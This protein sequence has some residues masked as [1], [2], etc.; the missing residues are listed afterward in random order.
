MSTRR[1][2]AALVAFAASLV[3]P[4]LAWATDSPPGKAVRE[5]I[6][7][8]GARY[9][10]PDKAWI[11]Q[12]VSLED[13]CRARF[14]MEGDV[15]LVVSPLATG[16]A[17][18]ASGTAAS[19]PATGSGA[20]VPTSAPGKNHGTAKGRASLAEVHSAAPAVKAALAEA[21]VRESAGGGFAPTWLIAVVLGAL[22]T[23]A[24]VRIVRRN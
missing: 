24:A 21:Q 16:V 1:V 10:T 3:L 12:Y 13:A 6:E 15:T 18:K 8:N 22:L 19:S 4:G 7:R 23:A 20:V 2:L 17:V 14:G 11:S 5:C 9:A